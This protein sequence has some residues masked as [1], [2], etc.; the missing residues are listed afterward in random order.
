MPD[1]IQPPS[2]SPELL[3]LSGRRAVA[4]AALREADPTVSALI[5]SVVV[6]AIDAASSTIVGAA[7]VLSPSARREV[8]A[9]LWHPAVDQCVSS[10][11]PASRGWRRSPVCSSA[12]AC[13]A[14]PSAMRSAHG[15]AELLRRQQ[16]RSAVSIGAF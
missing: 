11:S 5:V 14:R 3:S 1:P 15:G 7:A 2:R 10:C 12:G 8:L 13:A 4:A 16:A 6:D 9:A